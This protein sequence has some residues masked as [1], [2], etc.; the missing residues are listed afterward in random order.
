MGEIMAQNIEAVSGKNY[1]VGSAPYTSYLMSGG[2]DDWARG[3]LG[4]KWVFTL[5]LP[6]KGV[7]GFLLPPNQI[8][9]TGRSIF[10]GIRAMAAEISQMMV[11]FK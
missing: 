10:H 8:V 11:Y 9:P 1:I 7:F 2:S 4:I 5:E 6:D 3:E